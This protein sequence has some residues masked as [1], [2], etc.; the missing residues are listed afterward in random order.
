MRDLART[1]N[2]SAAICLIGCIEPFNL[3]NGT[4]GINPIDR[5]MFR[6]STRPMTLSS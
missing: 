3:T 4:D 6:S 5:P 2:P 1:G